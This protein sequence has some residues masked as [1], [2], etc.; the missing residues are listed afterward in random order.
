M[1]AGLFCKHNTSCVL[2]RR[3]NTALF[4]LE[5]VASSSRYI[6]TFHFFPSSSTFGDSHVPSDCFHCNPLYPNLLDL[7]LDFEH[8]C[9]LFSLKLECEKLVQEKTEMQ[10]H[11]VMV[12]SHIFPI[13]LCH[14]SS[15]HIFLSILLCDGKLRYFFPH[16]IV[17]Q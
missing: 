4:L 10:R 7:R 12:S 1:C 13:S 3:Q 11:Y 14:N 8:V 15:S 17:S 5:S 9:F 6:N 2:P 16:I